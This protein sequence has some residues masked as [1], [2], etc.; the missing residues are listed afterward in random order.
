MTDSRF[1]GE[2][3]HFCVGIFAV[4]AGAFL[5]AVHHYSASS[6]T[7][8][9]PNNALGVLLLIL[10]AVLAYTGVRKSQGNIS[11]SVTFC[12]TVSSLW[13]G[14]GINFILTGSDVITITDL[15]DAMVPGLAAFTLGLLI[16]GIVGIIHNEAVIALMAIALS[17]SA[18]H[19]IAMFY[20][21]SFGSSAIAC[22]YLIVTLIGAYFV[23]GRV[24]YIVSKTQVNLPGTGIAKGKATKQTVTKGT[25]KKECA[26]TCL[27]LNMVAASVFGCKLLGITSVLF[28][29]QVSWLWTAGVYQTGLCI[30]SYRS[31][32]MLDATVFAFFSILRFAE[33]YSLLYRN[34]NIDQPNFPLPFFVVFAVLFF[35]LSLFS[36]IKSLIDS[37]YLLFFVAYCIALA[38][39]PQAFF[40]QG[41]Q[42]VN[43]AIYVASGI[44]MLI[45]LYNIKSS[46]KIPTGKGVIK[47]LFR[48][49]NFFKLRQEKDLYNP[50][51]GTSKY[52]DAE[53][54]AHACSVLAAFAI[55]MP[56]DPGTPLMTVI[57]PWV[58]VAGG[59]YNL[60]CGSIAFSR[61]KTL[62][63]CAFTLYGIMWIIWGITR[64]GGL[65]G[66]NRGFN[67]AVGIICFMLFNTFIIFSTLFT[68]KAWFIYSLTFQ[69]IL[70][71]FLLDAVNA[72]PFGYDIGVTIIFGLASFYCFLATLFNSFFEGPQIP[73]GS[74]F[75]KISGVS[76]DKSKCP[77]LISSR[78]SSVRQIAEIMKNGG[79]CGIPTDT[80]YVLVAACNQP[81]AVEKAY[82]T[83]RQAQDRPM[84]LWIS[85]LQQLEAAKHLFSPLLW[86]FMQAAWPSSISLVIPRGEWLDVLGAKDSS[87]YIGTPQSIAIRIPDCA[88]TTHLIDMVGPIAV[89]SANPSG[90]ADTTHH[91][92]VY[93]KLGDKVDGVLCDGASPENIAS[94]VVDCTKLESGNVGFFRVGIVPKSQV[95]NIL[96]QVQQK[97][98]LGY[99]NDAFTA[100]EIP[101]Q[102]NA[103]SDKQNPILNKDSEDSGHK[104]YVNNGF[105]MHDEETKP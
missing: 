16:I 83:K 53:V 35:I 42:G 66:S 11:L 27:I 98:K 73:V 100:D 39:S 94:T 71:S 20:N 75:I 56:G 87:K 5:L 105:T 52:I 59:I 61:G 34:L 31:Y 68:S 38:C 32:S 48:Q 4:G 97:H 69:L 104:A 40:H 86:D 67:T 101:G 33:G 49:N 96:Q 1:R 3:L 19:E 14:S 10:A 29:G 50:F 36:S 103:S 12:W 54:L 70:I 15:K 72:L 43:I 2:S 9:I 22:N 74:A 82:K 18:I 62:E 57:L 51:L 88:V 26:I 7:S 28:V 47:K 24:F 78:T 99:D 65:Y 45:K 89:T 17:L 81:D 21:S 80:V 41:S 37:M 85:S 91:N 92:Q 79:I 30:L 44:V 77:H 6:S 63:S 8:V 84:S 90:E 25:N 60:I 58:V 64:Y 23:V 95:L 76:N 102:S 46:K 93:A 13:C 55:T